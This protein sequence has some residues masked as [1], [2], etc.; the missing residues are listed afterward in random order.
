M[1]RCSNKTTCIVSIGGTV[2]SALEPLY[3]AY[4]LHHPSLFAT[5]SLFSTLIIPI[6]ADFLVCLFGIWCSHPSL[7]Q[8]FFAQIQSKMT[9]VR[10]RLSSSCTLYC[11]AFIEEGTFHMI[12]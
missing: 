5:L 8:D 1:H 6:H 11:E 10:E 7:G 12:G 2:Y 4:K 3:N 9:R